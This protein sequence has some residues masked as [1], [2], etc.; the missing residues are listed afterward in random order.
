MAESSNFAFLK[1][2]DPL[3]LQLASTA[4]QV[5][6][7]DPNTT[8]IKLRQLSSLKRLIEAGHSVFHVE[9]LHAKLVLE[10]GVA[11]T[12]GSQNLTIKGQKNRELTA[13]LFA[14]DEPGELDKIDDLIAPWLVSAELITMQMITEMEELIRPLLKAFEDLQGTCEAGSKRILLYAKARRLD[15]ERVLREAE[16]AR[17]RKINEQLKR[18]ILKAISR[19]KVSSNTHIGTVNYRNNENMSLFGDNFISWDFNGKK[20]WLSGFIRYLCVNKNGDIG[21]VRLTKTRIS[22]IETSV[23]FQYGFLPEMP[24]WRLAVSRVVKSDSFYGDNYNLKLQIRSGG[25]LVCTVPARFVIDGLS[26][27]DCIPADATNFMSSDFVER[28][29]RWVQDNR[30]LFVNAVVKQITTPFNYS[31]MLSGIDAS[32]FGG[33]L[34]K[35]KVKLGLVNGGYFIFCS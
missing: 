3:F 31:K 16:Q 20:V 5:F 11:A 27:G 12:V 15:A 22:M 18:D 29:C 4:E 23:Y 14:E 24:D 28:S 19:S 6:A 33:Y 1:E 34:T 13:A 32:F 21:W 25:Q 2:H 26:I 9:G 7:A 35:H 8:L 17:D 30:D 10:R